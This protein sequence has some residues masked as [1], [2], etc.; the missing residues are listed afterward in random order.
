MKKLVLAFAAAATLGL[1]ALGS[2][3]S[4]EAKWGGHGFKGHGG[5]HGKFHG[6][7]WG[8]GHWGHR[9]WGHGHRYWG[10]R[11]GGVRVVS[12]SGGYGSCWRQRWTP[13]GYRYVNVCVRPLYY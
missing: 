3:T 10:H 12:Y 1:T 2:S 11:W 7:H 13:Y 5:F 8:G 9:H 4:A 6:G